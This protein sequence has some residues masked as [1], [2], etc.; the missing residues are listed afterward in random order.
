MPLLWPARSRTLPLVPISRLP[1]GNPGYDCVAVLSPTTRFRRYWRRAPARRLFCQ[2]TKKR[3]AAWGSSAPRKEMKRPMSYGR[4]GYRRLDVS[5]PWQPRYGRVRAGPKAAPRWVCKFARAVE[6]RGGGGGW[7]LVMPPVT[8]SGRRRRRSSIGMVG[9][10]NCTQRVPIG[11]VSCLGPAPPSPSARPAS[12]PTAAQRG[13][14]LR[15]RAAGTAVPVSIGRRQSLVAVRTASSARPTAS[16]TF[17]AVFS[18]VPLA[19]IFL[20]PI[21][22]PTASLTEPVAWRSAPLMRFL[23]MTP[24]VL[25]E[26]TALNHNSRRP[27]RRI[28]AM[29]QSW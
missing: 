21:T 19:C 1:G 15:Q 11:R 2:A 22:L 8:R 25:P 6:H 5:A 18:A 7:A 14:G 16:W 3:R 9:K 28:V 10:A 20:S 17:P 23:S 26:E 24:S 4:R 12:R 27:T 29:S 13:R